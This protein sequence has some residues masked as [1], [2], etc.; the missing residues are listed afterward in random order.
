MNT[1]HNGQCLVAA[2]AAAVLLTINLSAQNV[3]PEERQFQRA[4]RVEQGDG[5]LDEAIKIYEGLIARGSRDA[6]VTRRALLRLAAIYET[7]GKQSGDDSAALYRR[8]VAEFPNSDEATRARQKI[9]ELT[10]RQP[11]DYEQRK[12]D[13]A[14]SIP[15]ATVVATDG[16]RVVY[17]DR[18]SGSLIISTVGGQE[19]RVVHQ[20]RELPA[21]SIAS[22]D[23]SLVAAY[24]STFGAPARWVLI[25]TNGSGS[26][27][28]ALNEPGRTGTV[29]D[30][31]SWS[32]DNRFLL[33]CQQR[34]GGSHLVRVSVADGTAT[35][36]HVAA[37]EL[38]SV[39]YS[40]DGRHIAF[41]RKA[42]AG[43]RPVVYV[44]PAAGGEAREVGSG[45][46][47]DWTPD[48]RFLVVHTRAAS[49]DVQTI[50]VAIPV[51]DGR[52]AGD[53]VP[54]ALPRVNSFS[55]T[56][57]KNGAMVVRMTG[58]PL[59]QVF[60]TSLDE[61]GKLG[62]WKLERLDTTQPAA[63][64][65]QWSPDGRALVYVARRDRVNAVLVR[66]IATGIDKEIHRTAENVTSCIWG[67][68]PSQVLCGETAAEP[69]PAPAV[70]E[71]ASRGTT[72]F[73]LDIVTRQ[74]EVLG[75]ADGLQHLI[76]LSEDGRTLNTVRFGGGAPSSEGWDIDARRK[77]A[78][79]PAPLKTPSGPAIFEG[80]Q[81][82][83]QIRFGVR[84]LAP[85]SSFRP[86]F[87]RRDQ[88]AS[89]AQLGFPI[90]VTADGRWVFYHDRDEAG[91]DGLYRVAVDGGQPERLGDHP[92][93]EPKRG[94]WLALSPDGR[95]ILVAALRPAVSEF[96]AVQNIVRP[97]P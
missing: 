70:P 34:V 76:E 92:T 43:A 3:S 65:P 29:S 26:R 75:V 79:A 64:Y 47:A 86:L 52:P 55:L 78:A 9:A 31:G 61:D 93:V 11:P 85:G 32:W 63:A 14:P 53:P 62:A 41:S 6:G 67:R 54:T 13:L 38:E 18:D 88:T 40:P 68:T 82:E 77:A 73:A 69:R 50:R 8:L 35:T 94:S 96:Y 16:Q 58:N 56:T 91:R 7:R 57:M 36:L 95:R 2:L 60:T 46:L 10:A 83:G 59:G 17:W 4:V 49:Q 42:A 24:Y 1:S 72:L 25:P 51:R 21:H 22:P 27:D 30:C 87:T 33:L 89:S 97:S 84:P 28:L 15:M 23:L 80:E 71:L 19:R 39:S 44:V 90:R 81:L 74:R 20:S 45:R 48:G 37:E 12:V 5:N 66:D